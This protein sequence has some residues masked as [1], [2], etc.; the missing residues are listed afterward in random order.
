[1]RRALQAVS[2]LALLA[3]IGPPVLFLTGG[4]NWPP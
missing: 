2:A 1:M 3:T 4:S